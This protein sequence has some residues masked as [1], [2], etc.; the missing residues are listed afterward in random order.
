MLSCVMIEGSKTGESEILVLFLNEVVRS[1]LV[2]QGKLRGTRALT[3][4]AQLVEH[5]YAKHRFASWILLIP[6]WGR[7][8]RCGRSPARLCA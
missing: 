1:C 2:S 4:V 6:S 5:R 8:L 7:C 3:G